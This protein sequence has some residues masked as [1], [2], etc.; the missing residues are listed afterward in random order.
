VTFVESYFNEHI[1]MAESQNLLSKGRAEVLRIANLEDKLVGL[2]AELTEG[3]RDWRRGEDPYQSFR[4]LLTLRNELVHYKPEFTPMG[5]FPDP[6]VEQIARR[7]RHEWFGRCDWTVAV[8]TANV[9]DWAC[10]TVRELV[11]EFHRMV[12]TRNPWQYG[13]PGLGDEDWQPLV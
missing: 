4:Q 11:E 3:R 8:L 6:T 13:M 2:L 5:E 10:R 7:F 9:A 12:G 1:A